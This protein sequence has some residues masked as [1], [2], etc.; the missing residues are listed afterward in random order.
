MALKINKS[1]NISLKR[2]RSQEI[3]HPNNMDDKTMRSLKRLRV[4][5]DSDFK[6]EK[7]EKKTEDKVEKYVQQLDD[8]IVKCTKKIKKL[9]EKTNLILESLED[10]KKLYS[11][12]EK[13]NAELSW[14]KEHFEYLSREHDE[15]IKK[16]RKNN[17]YN[18]LI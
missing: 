14:Y 1:I 10:I 15:L 11:K 17:D 13:L 6:I 12:N 18:Y 2:E 3:Y 9:D 8:K 7:L 5:N 4:S 16:N